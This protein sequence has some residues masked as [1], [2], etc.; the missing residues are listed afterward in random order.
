MGGG[1]APRQSLGIPQRELWVGKWQ[2]IDRRIEAGR[3]GV[4]ALIRTDPPMPTA[5]SNSMSR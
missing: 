3:D 1:V 4:A 5:R 2:Q